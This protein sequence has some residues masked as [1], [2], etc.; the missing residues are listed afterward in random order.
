MKSST[1]KP[2][3]NG[4]SG[5]SGKWNITAASLGTEELAHLEMVG[6]I[7]YQLTRCLTPE[8]IEKEGFADYFVDHTTGVYPPPLS[9]PATPSRTSTRT[10][11]RSRRPGSAMTTSCALPTTR[12][13]PS[14]SSSCGSGRS[15]TISAS[16]RACASSPTGWTAKTSTPSTPPSTSNQSFGAGGSPAGPAFYFSS[17]LARVSTAF[18]ISAAVCSAS[19]NAL[20]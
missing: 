6:T 15:C 1:L 12:T 5:I 3:N 14:P 13:W 18:A 9:P 7:V 8:Q 17:T 19:R 2:V 11:R 4:C 20:L 16:A 10:W